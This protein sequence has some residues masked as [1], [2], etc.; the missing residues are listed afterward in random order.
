MG[1]FELVKKIGIKTMV[2]LRPREGGFC[3]TAAEFDTMLADARLFREAGADGAVFGILLPDGS[4]DRVRCG[5]LMEELSGMETVFHRAMDETPDWREALDAL[6]GLGFT[7]V[8]TSGQKPTASEGAD[9]LAAM[10]KYAAGRVEI[11][12]GGGIRQG[13]VRALIE[14]TGCTQVHFSTRKG[15]GFLSARELADLVAAVKG[16]RRG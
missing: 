9:T 11:L 15:S 1:V 7:R 16:I 4:V 14:K 13:N 8:L 2:M 3:Y 5:K 12:P 6:A 10:V